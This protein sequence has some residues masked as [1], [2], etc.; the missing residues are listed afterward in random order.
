MS[1]LITMQ[2]TEEQIEKILELKE[3]II[4]KM[5]EAPRRIRFSTEKFGGTWILP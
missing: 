4:D 1:F 2:Y 3:S 5:T